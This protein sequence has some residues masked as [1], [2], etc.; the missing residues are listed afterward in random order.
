MRANA[1]RDE[2]DNEDDDYEDERRPI[3]DRPLPLSVH[4]KI[5]HD[6]ARRLLE[7]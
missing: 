2:D 5:F 7:R 3:W 6:N 1:D 4:R